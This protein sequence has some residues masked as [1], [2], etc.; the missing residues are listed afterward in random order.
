MVLVRPAR[1]AASGAMMTSSGDTC[2]LAE[3][4]WRA[5]RRRSL[6][7]HQSSVVP[8]VSPVAVSTD[9]CNSP[10]PRRCSITSGTPPAMKTCTVGWPRG[11]LGRASTRRGVARLTRCQSLTVGGVIPAAWAIAGIC[12]S[13]LVDPPKAACTSM[14][15]SMACCVR[16]PPSGRPRPC[17]LSRAS[18]DRRPSSNHDGSPDGASALCGR[19]SPSASAT[20]CD[21]AAVPRNWHPPPAEPQARHPISAA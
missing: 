11:P 6:V 20:T 21:V 3:R 7:S 8:K 15:F 12:N 18:A 5:A 4:R 1:R 19:A 16:M 14:A 2:A 9:S 17:S 13:R 10:I